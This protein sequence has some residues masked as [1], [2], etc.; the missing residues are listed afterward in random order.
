MTRSVSS[1]RL[2][3]AMPVHFLMPLPMPNA[4]CCSTDHLSCSDNEF[5]L[6][7]NTGRTIVPQSIGEYLESKINDA[8]SHVKR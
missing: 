3:D 5:T 7:D 4:P 6:I 8:Q 1:Q 2:C